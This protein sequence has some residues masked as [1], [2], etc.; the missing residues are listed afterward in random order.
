[1]N[2]DSHNLFRPL[3]IRDAALGIA[4]VSLAVGI[5]IVLIA[6]LGASTP[7]AS[8]AGGGGST[9]NTGGSGTGGAT[10]GGVFP[11]RGKHSYGD[12]FGAGRSHQGQDVFAKCGTRMV[13]AVGGRVQLRAKH[14]AAGNYLVI[15]TKGSK[16][17]H[18]YMHLKRPSRL[19]RGDRVATGGLIG[20]VGETGNASGCH[21][22]FEMWKPGYYE[23]GRSHPLRSVTKSLR[24][25]DRKS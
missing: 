7:Q 2:K 11:V 23:N 24:S 15:D 1:M 6:L 9:N 5:L 14:S 21:L 12:G 25:W 3:S 4:L 20:K 17:D 18:V 19:G 10:K 22:H 16:I 13:A 8:A